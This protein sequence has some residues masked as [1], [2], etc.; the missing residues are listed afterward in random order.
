MRRERTAAARPPRTRDPRGEPDRSVADIDVHRKEESPP[1][2]P[3]DRGDEDLR[4]AGAASRTPAIS[5]W[6]IASNSERRMSDLYSAAIL[7]R[8]SHHN[9]GQRIQTDPEVAVHLELPLRLR[10]LGGRGSVRGSPCGEPARLRTGLQGSI[11]SDPGIRGP[12]HPPRHR[13]PPHRTQWVRLGRAPCR[14]RRIDPLGARPLRERNPGDRPHCAPRSSCSGGTPGSVVRPGVGAPPPA[15]T[16][17]CPPVVPPFFLL[18]G[19]PGSVFGTGVGRA[20]SV[21][22]SRYVAVRMK[23]LY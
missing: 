2:D 21:L 20:P 19:T 10:R 17:P 8:C 4:L 7:A 5:R 23:W 15:A 18:R 14:R 13:S 11:P 1:G 6:Q 3:G 12:L 16:P 22:S 9:Y